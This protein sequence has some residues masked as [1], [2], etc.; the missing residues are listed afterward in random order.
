MTSF[1]D[2]NRSPMEEFWLG[3]DSVY[4]QVL[5]QNANVDA[6]CPEQ[7]VVHI[8]DAHEVDDTEWLI[9][10]ELSSN[11]EIFFSN[12][13][14]EL[15][16]VWDALGVGLAGANGGF[17][18][19]LDNW[20]LEGFNED[21]VYARYNDVVY[22]PGQLAGLGDLNNATAFPPLINNTRVDNDISFAMFAIADT[23]VYNGSEVSMAFLDRLGNRVLGYAN[24]DCVFVEVV[25][26]DQDE[27]QHRRERI[28]GFWDWD[29]VNNVGQNIPFGPVAT[30][31]LNC[32][33]DQGV[34]THPVN[35]LLGHTHILD[36]AAVG[37][38][39]ANAKLYVLNPRNGRWQVIDLLETG[40]DT[41]TFRNVTCIPLVD[42]EICAR[43]L[44]VLPGDT[45]IAVYMDPSNHSDIAWISIKVGVGG[46][47]GYDQPS[48]TQFT[49]E[50][51]ISVAQYTE[52]DAIFVKVTDPSH[53]GKNS[54]EGLAIDGEAFALFPFAGGADD[55]FLTPAISLAELGVC[56]G[57]TLTATYTDPTDDNDTSTD[58]I[59]VVSGDLIVDGPLLKPNPFSAVVAFTFKGQ[60]VPKTFEVT[61]YDLVGRR[62]W[63]SGVRTNVAEI[64]WDGRDQS[65]RLLANGPYF[66]VMTL[67]GADEPIDPMKGKVFIHR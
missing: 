64:P 29:N 14:L 25:D 52:G 18:L 13:G 44:G 53:A 51:G 60:G 46:G 22:P 30:G 34:Q 2:A 57:A 10:D 28:D 32:G 33:V 40:T 21:H 3:R 24:S 5:D 56:G 47:G 61:V 17:Q 41:A 49:D 48:A 23:Q 45:I 43:Q 42:P 20:A 12:Q 31:W 16:S 65:G 55:E 4:A 66:F 1:T 38:N 8:C 35:A 39:G 36:N 6:C 63:E 9:L 26:E 67:T 62:M 59:D 15:A 19:Q 54:L 27:D 58:T 11:T 7:V 50:Q 37:A